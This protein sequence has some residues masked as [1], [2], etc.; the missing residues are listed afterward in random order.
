MKKLN[1]HFERKSLA[2]DYLKIVYQG[3]INRIALLDVRRTGKTSFLLKDFFPVA[4]KH[5][6][7]PI[8]INLWLD[9]VNPSTA[10]ISSIRSTL[11]ALDETSS[12][13]LKNLAA[14]NIRKIE[15]GNSLIG[16]LGVEFADSEVKTVNSSDL[17]E[18]N[19]LIEKL[20]NKCGDKAIL[21][22]DEIQHLSSSAKFDSIQRSLRTALDTHNELNVIY[23]GSSRSGIDAM[24]ADKDKAF[25]NSAMMIDLPRLGD[26]FVAHC[27]EILKENFDLSYN[28]S[29]LIDFYHSVDRSPYWMMQLS[30][31]LLAYKV[32]LAE[33]IAFI[34]DLIIADG[35][36]ER[37]SQSLNKTDK[38]VLHFVL[39]NKDRI[40]TEVSMNKLSVLTNVKITPS[41][42]QTSIIKLKSKGV[43]SQCGKVFY[44]EMHGFLQYLNNEN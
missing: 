14:T 41:K 42:I 29:D 28:T 12:V 32:N 11:D 37:M 33:A 15:V 3:A 16:K 6:F 39:N 34:S 4:L 27:R 24:F 19:T 8:Y 22:I 38:A 36:F 44:M 1:W 40:Y 9:P 43:I 2:E 31:Y 17:L 26:E 5:K 21:I 35:G 20:V 10:I 25:F 18:I 7:V 23:S 30:N 13:K